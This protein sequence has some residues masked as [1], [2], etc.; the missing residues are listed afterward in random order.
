V[1]S[2]VNQVGAILWKDLLSELRTRDLLGGMVLFGVLVL[3]IFNF[4]F[5]LRIDNVA[6]VAPG[7]LW[8]AFSFAGMLGLAR[9]FVQEKDRGA[10]DGLLSAPIDRGA[11]YLAKFVGNVLFMS[12]VEA[13][14][15]PVFTAF[16]NF[17]VV[18]LDVIAIAFLGTCGFAAVGTL[19]SA[20]AANTRA[21]DVMLPLLVFPISVPVVIAAVEATASTFAG[22]PFETR[23]RW[24]A[25]LG[26]F[27]VIFG[28]LCFAVFDVVVEE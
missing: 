10:M 12:V 8:V 16:F 14:C 26:A 4:A 22:G 11:I 17:G 3:V 9:S 15:L 1:T 28:V 25:L 27:D 2:L 13:V 18:S 23:L 20:M 7:V 5:D 19:F 21:R 6:A 24:L